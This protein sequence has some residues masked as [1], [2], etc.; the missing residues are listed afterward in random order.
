MPSFSN[1]QILGH[2]GQDARTFTTSS[3]TQGVNL[4]VAVST[5]RDKPPT[6]FKIVIFRN[7]GEYSR[8]QFEIAGDCR[9]GDLVLVSGRVSIDTWNDKNSGDQRAQLSLVA[10]EFYK[11]GGGY[12]DKTTAKMDD[13][14]PASEYPGAGPDEI[15]F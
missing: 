6:W 7:E 5:G 10:R 8:V 14:P 1:T 12:A 4:S 11:M 9:K 3:G 13:L 2:C 15:P